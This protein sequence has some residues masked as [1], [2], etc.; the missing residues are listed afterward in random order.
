MNI[1]ETYRVIAIA[2]KAL[3]TREREIVRFIVRDFLEKQIAAELG[4]SISTVDRHLQNVYQKLR[5]H[6]RVQ[7]VHWA[8]AHGLVTPITDWSKQ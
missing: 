4:I 7:L 5:I 3:T 6:S 1:C 8:I 2:D